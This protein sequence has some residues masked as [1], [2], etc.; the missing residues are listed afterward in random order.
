M[1]NS[2]ELDET[3]AVH[4][5]NESYECCNCGY[6]QCWDS[7]CEFCGEDELKII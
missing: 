7:P 2:H 4:E 3:W 1:E 6:I 5:D